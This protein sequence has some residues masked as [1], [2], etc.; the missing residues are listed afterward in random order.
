MR[1]APAGEAVIERVTIG[2]GPYIVRESKVL[3]M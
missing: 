3:S 1:G 2:R